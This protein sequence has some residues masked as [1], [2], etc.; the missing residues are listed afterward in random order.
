MFYL[1]KNLLLLIMVIFKLKCNNLIFNEIKV[2]NAS[3]VCLHAFSLR[4][5]SPD[6]DPG[7]RTP[8]FCGGSVTPLTSIGLLHT[9]SLMKELDGGWYCWLNLRPDGSTKGRGSTIGWEGRG[10]VCGYSRLQGTSSVYVD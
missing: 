8:H 10:V 1:L 9:C 6:P 2:L 3:Y 7:R 5:E 4:R